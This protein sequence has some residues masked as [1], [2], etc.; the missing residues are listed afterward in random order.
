MLCAIDGSARSTDR[1][2]LAMDLSVVQLSIDHAVRSE[3]YY[4]VV[5]PTDGAG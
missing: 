2:V 5:A 1:T 3:D 4:S